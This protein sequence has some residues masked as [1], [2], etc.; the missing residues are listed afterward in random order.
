VEPAFFSRLKGPSFQPRDTVRA[1]VR[2]RSVAPEPVY[3][4]G[5]FQLDPR[6]RLLCLEGEPVALPDRHL[7]ILRLLVARAGDIVAKDDLIEMAWKDVAVSDNSLEQAM[8]SLRRRLGPAPDGAPYIE[9][10]ARRGYRFR[11]PVT[12]TTARESDDTLSALLKPYRMFVEGRAAIE[13]LERDAVHRAAE[14]FEQVLALAP[15]YAP[16]HIGLANAAALAFD[17]TR[18]NVVPDADALRR[19]VHHAREACRLDTDSGEAWATLAFVL[20]RMGAG[21]D[22]VAAGRRATSLEPDNWR[23]YVRLAYAAWGDERL[24]AAR[25]AL[26]RL[27]EFGLAH[28][29]AATVHVARL[30]LDD[31]TRELAAGAAAQDRQPEGGRFGSVGLHLL[32]GLVHD[33]Q[34]DRASA[35]REI[36]RELSFE[37]SGHIYS[38]HVCASTWYARGAL[39]QHEGRDTDAVVAFGAALERAPAHP[40]ALAAL[41]ELTGGSKRRA[42]RAQLQQRL[43]LLLQAGATVDAAA[44]AAVADVLAGRHRAAAE[45]VHAAL[46]HA[47]EGSSSGWGIP[48]DPLLRV[49][50][51]TDA[52][53]PV[54][55]L[56]RARAS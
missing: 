27:P 36:E 46:R 17:S 6:R 25:S 2:I 54:L 44:A 1:A 16:G 39:R 32:L 14:A 11:L 41:A 5:P 37:A 8:S 12:S 48:I 29:L 40:M 50:E 18:S 26:K 13:T 15:D 33:A 35:D 3:S 10:L 19:A 23:H 34:G 31:A 56:L 22:A 9:T 47:P 53:S 43:A 42:F 55:V 7:D 52:W 38:M 20:S 4:F 45:R 51:H 24:R 21:G 28:W 30:A 49:T